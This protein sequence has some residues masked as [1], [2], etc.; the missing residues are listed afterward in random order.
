MKYLHESGYIHLDIKPSNFFVAQKGILKLGDFNLTRKKNKFNDDYFE[1]D[2]TYMA[3]EILEATKIKELN[4][5]CDI[6]SLGLTI[7]EILFKVELP[8]NGVLWRQIRS[9]NF[10]IPDDFISNTNLEEIPKE[11]FELI[12]GMIHH[13]PNIRYNVQQIFENF[14]EIKSRMDKLNKELYVSSYEDFV[15]KN[16]MKIEVGVSKSIVKKN[17]I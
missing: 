9:E 12:Y 17:F 8:Q 15:V 14:R 3:P 1:G 6:F 7:I 10:K 4:E 11:F 5:K 2:S 16:D 13:D